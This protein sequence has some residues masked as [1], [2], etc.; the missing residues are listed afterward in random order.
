MGRRNPNVSEILQQV[1]EQMKARFN[2]DGALKADIEQAQILT[3]FLSTLKQRA[4]ERKN[5]R[6]LNEDFYDMI[7]DNI[8]LPNGRS[9]YKLFTRIGNTNKDTGQKFEDDLAAVIA[10]VV[11]LSNPDKKRTSYKSFSLGSVTGTV[12]GLEKI[13]D[14]YAHEYVQ[15]I[16]EETANQI[17]K[18]PPSRMGKI[19]TIVNQEIINLNANFNIPENILKALSNATFTDKSY[20]SKGWDKT[21][22]KEIDL[23]NT[24]IHLGNSQP[25]RSILGSMTA[26]GFSQNDFQYIYYAGRNIVAGLDSDPPTESSDFV[27]QHIYHLRYMYELT[28]AGIIYKNFSGLTDQGAKFL[29]YNDPNSAEII[30][31]STAQIISQLL[32]T[33]NFPDNPYGAIGIAKAAI[34]TIAH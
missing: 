21:L 4:L 30:C 2:P 11:N 8:K 3:N 7:L 5:G 14:D 34:R 19:D 17:K 31:V 12:G 25:Y 32:N 15:Q 13:V 29:I 23:G 18:E 24:V 10:S 6:N 9:I 20:R 1:H 22:G 33:E 27:K 28:G 16:V 26:L